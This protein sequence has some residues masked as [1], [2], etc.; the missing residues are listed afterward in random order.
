MFWVLFLLAPVGKKTNDDF[1]KMF[2]QNNEADPFFLTTNAIVNFTGGFSPRR[3]RRPWEPR[4]TRR[5]R[6]PRRRWRTKTARDPPIT[7]PLMKEPWDAYRAN[8]Y[9]SMVSMLSGQCNVNLDKYDNDGQTILMAASTT[10]RANVVQLMLDS[11]ANI[12]LKDG[13]MEYTA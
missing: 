7:V 1:L 6:G 3:S 4:K 12:E 10:G 2:G 8:D 11:C 13:L 5:P 9:E